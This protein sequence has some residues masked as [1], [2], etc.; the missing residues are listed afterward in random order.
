MLGGMKGFLG[1]M[2]RSGTQRIVYHIPVR[3]SRTKGS[4]KSTRAAVVEKKVHYTC[5]AH[6]DKSSLGSKTCRLHGDGVITC[7]LCKSLDEPAPSYLESLAS[8]P[9]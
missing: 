5:Y 1:S 4:R 8:S 6:L 9:A 2:L 7:T 3:V